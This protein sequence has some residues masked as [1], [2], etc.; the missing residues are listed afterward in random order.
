MKK[1]YNLEFDSFIE[2]KAA[3]EVFEQE[4]KDDH[5]RLKKLLIDLDID[6]EILD[7]YS[8]A[9]DLDKIKTDVDMAKVK[10]TLDR[11]SPEFI[12]KCSE[13]GVKVNN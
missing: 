10:D 9:I 12:L 6:F 4:A 11:I 7:P 5:E 2:L 1:K 13:V 3:Y 8:V